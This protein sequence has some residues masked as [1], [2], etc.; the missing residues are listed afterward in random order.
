MN[1][2]E[3]RLSLMRASLA[4][5]LQLAGRW[6]GEGQAHGE[7]IR[8][9]LTVRVSF[10]ATMLELEEQSGEHQDRCYY[11]YEPDED[12]FL[13]LH[14]MAGSVREYPVETTIEGLF[15]V[16]PPAEPAVEWTIRGAGLRQE[17][18]WPDQ[19]GTEVQIDYRRVED[20]RE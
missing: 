19:E 12:R 15:W 10:D 16:T 17:V 2:W 6:E 13:V 7:P 3:R 8:S 20:A 11:R 9:V 1:P 18:L 14:L 4:P 5:F